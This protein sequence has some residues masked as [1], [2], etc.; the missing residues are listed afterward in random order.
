[1]H[2]ST[3]IET[4]SSTLAIVI[5]L[6][7]PALVYWIIIA[8]VNPSVDKFV[9]VKD[10]RDIYKP[11]KKK[12]KVYAVATPIRKLLMTLILTLF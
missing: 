8:K 7:F 4:L 5:L 6:C 2:F 3:L 12:L 1:M 11:Y 10:P 9:I